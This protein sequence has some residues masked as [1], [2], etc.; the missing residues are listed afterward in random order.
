MYRNAGMKEQVK[1]SSILQLSCSLQALVWVGILLLLCWGRRGSC[2]F[3]FWFLFCLVYIP[4]E[5]LTF[6]TSCYD[7]TCFA[8]YNTTA[9]LICI[10]SYMGRSFWNQSDLLQDPVYN[11]V[12]YNGLKQFGCHQ[13]LKTALTAQIFFVI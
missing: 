9:Q 13:L 2:Q 10:F 5:S 11:N 4:G 7:T 6:S 12:I 8:V 1:A 3:G